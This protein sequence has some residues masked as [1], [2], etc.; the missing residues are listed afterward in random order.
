MPNENTA[1]LNGREFK[2]FAQ[3]LSHQGYSLEEPL[4]HIL[5][6]WRL[7]MEDFR[8]AQLLD[9]TEQKEKYR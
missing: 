5:L 4:K 7:P 9:S 2:Y 3:E 6:F 1:K 8:A